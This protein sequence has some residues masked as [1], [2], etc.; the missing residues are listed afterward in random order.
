MSAT[1]QGKMFERETLVIL[2]ELLKT[3]DHKV[4]ERK[5]GD[6]IFA[7]RLNPDRIIKF[8]KKTQA[9]CTTAPTTSTT[10]EQQNA[11]V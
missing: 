7:G 2:N 8:G 5:N 11:E 10:N 4:Q 1:E 9:L 3:T 6:T